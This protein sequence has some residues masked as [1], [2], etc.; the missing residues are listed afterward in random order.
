MKKQKK[1]IKNIFSTISTAMAADI[2][3]DLIRV[4][5]ASVANTAIIPMQD[6]LRLGGD[7]RMNLPG[8]TVNN[9]LWRMKADDLKTELAEELAAL[10]KLYDRISK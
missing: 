8:T 5:W 9:W 6:L 1:P 4:A 7:A 2:C 10:T 3:K